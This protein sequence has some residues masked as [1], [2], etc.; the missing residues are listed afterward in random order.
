MDSNSRSKGDVEGNVFTKRKYWAMKSAQFLRVEGAYIS[1]HTSKQN[2]SV[3]WDADLAGC[4]ISPA[5]RPNSFIINLRDDSPVWVT[6]D[7]KDQSVR[8]WVAVLGKASKINFE[9]DYTLGEQIGEGAFASVHKAVATES[10]EE[11][12]V[13]VIVK[14]QFDNRSAREL[15]RE[16]LACRNLQVPGV[17]GTRGVYQTQLKVFIVMDLMPGGTLKK[18]V[19]N[20]GNRVGEVAVSQI[21][22]TTLS[23]LSSMHEAGFVHRDIKL[24]NIL[25]LNDS[26]P[27]E[28]VICDFGYVQV[29][30]PGAET[31]RSRVGTTVYVAPEMAGRG[32]YGAEV[33][34]WAVGV[35]GYRMICGKYPFGKGCEDDESILEC[36]LTTEVSFSEREWVNVSAAC[37]HLI[38]GLL[39]KNPAARLTA[40]AALKHEWMATA[41]KH[42]EEEL[43]PDR[44]PLPDREESPR[45][46]LKSK[47]GEEIA[48]S[49][50]KSTKSEL[51]AERIRAVVAIG[52]RLASQ[53]SELLSDPKSSSQQGRQSSS[54]EQLHA[55]EILTAN[56]VRNIVKSNADALAIVESV[57]SPGSSVCSQKSGAETKNAIPGTESP[58][59]TTTTDGTDTTSSQVVRTQ[60][61]PYLTGTRKKPS[62]AEALRRVFSSSSSTPRAGT[63]GTSRTSGRVRSSTNLGNVFGR[64]KNQERLDVR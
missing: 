61:Q 23:T 33:D 31:M 30:H 2:L 35:M 44:E 19:Q 39:E 53:L 55:Q 20:A 11:V 27:P 16:M 41:A 43:L 54:E 10:G 28:T 12:A 50:S 26:L 51:E 32:Q 6:L 64:R 5:L 7:G 24:E 15:D 56:S 21:M 58:K 9:C 46:V 4:T 57:L 47:K 49:S 25:C 8:E 34:L 62:R 45:S 1:A 13:K 63:S 38:R 40:K 14:Q 42:F 60:S 29:I 59:R 37:K 3:V 36:I 18:V 17:V 48:S 52:D 22:H